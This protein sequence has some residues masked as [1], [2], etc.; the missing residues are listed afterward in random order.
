[1]AGSA[2]TEVLGAVFIA[3]AAAQVGKEIAQRLKLPGVVGEIAAGCAVGPFALNWI[4][5]NQVPSLELF[6]ELG[7]VFL[8]FAVGLET[9][10]ADMRRIGKIAFLVGSLGV[11]VPF[12]LAAGFGAAQNYSLAKTL[13]FASAFVATSAGITAAVLQEK[14]LLSKRESQVILGAAVI[15]DILAMLLLGV[16]SSVS[17][18]KV[19]LAELALVVVQAIGFIVLIGYLGTR[20]MKKAPALL[21]KPI[22][23]KSPLAL[24][25][26]LC[27][28][29]AF[30]AAQIGLAA[31]IGAFLAGMI[32]AE[33]KHQHALA[34][35]VRSISELLVPFFFVYTGIQVNFGILSSMDTVLFIL[36][37]TA[38]ATLGKWVGGYFGARKLGHQSANVIGFG[39]VPR[40]EV[41]III[42]S[43]GYKAEIFDEKL[44]GIVIAMSLIT[45]IIAPPLITR[46]FARIKESK[47]EERMEPA[48]NPT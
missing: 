30:L 38:L 19:D 8:L 17:K 37:V 33:T 41:G 14:G 32:V 27:I 40:G 20:V 13:F 5:K 10:L 28:G 43:L 6:A 12:L 48:T 21:D 31:I 2:A 29:L 7:A 45:A 24:S 18:G 47:E 22:N 35:E 36:V 25:I 42:A 16:V 15:D 11:V 46:G 1:M 23:P 26:A 4:G 34:E 9:R 3:F 39:M 44:Y